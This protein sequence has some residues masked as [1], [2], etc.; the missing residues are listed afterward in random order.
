[1]SK[2][3]NKRFRSDFY[4]Y[5]LCTKHNANTIIRQLDELSDKELFALIDNKDR[6]LINDMYKN[7]YNSAALS[8]KY[9][10]SEKKISKMLRQAIE[11][12][13]T[14]FIGGYD[15]DIDQLK[16]N[17]LLEIYDRGVYSSLNEKGETLVITVSNKHQFSVRTNQ[18]N[19]WIRINEYYYDPD[20]KL[21]TDTETYDK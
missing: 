11:R 12:V 1:M 8:T 15:M 4:M 7:N 5:L 2:F 16:S 13:Y 18:E 6:N 19:G 20:T 17:V 3:D 9:K 10:V 14:N 21:W